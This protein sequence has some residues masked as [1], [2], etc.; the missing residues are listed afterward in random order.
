MLLD[1]LPYNSRLGRTDPSQ[2]QD[3]DT[4]GQCCVRLL[5]HLCFGNFQQQHVPVRVGVILPAAA[6]RWPRAEGGWYAPPN[7]AAVRVQRLEET[8]SFPRSHCV[9]G[10]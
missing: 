1:V 7:G 8:L 4:S 6:I 10:P 2:V 3:N 5:F 9:C